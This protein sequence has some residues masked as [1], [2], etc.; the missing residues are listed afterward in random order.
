MSPRRPLEAIKQNLLDCCDAPQSAKYI[1]DE[2]LAAVRA[3]R[4][5]SVHLDRGMV[6]NLR[7]VAG[8]IRDA[9]GSPRSDALRLEDIADAIE[10]SLA[11]QTPVAAQPSQADE[12]QTDRLLALARE[13]AF[14]LHWCS[15]HPDGDRQ[16]TFDRFSAAQVPH[17][18][19]M[20]D[21]PHPDC[22]LVTERIN[23]LPRGPVSLAP[24]EGR[25]NLDAIRHCLRVL[26]DDRFLILLVDET[27][28]A[29]AYISHLEAD[30][31][32]LTRE[33]RVH[34]RNITEG[35]AARKAEVAAL[36]A[37]VSRLKAERST[38]PKCGEH[39]MCAAGCED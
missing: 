16:A 30:L 3:E 9:S 1:L 2:L 39:R 31:S 27:H 32:R 4:P 20:D 34:M 35:E 25:P 26:E 28:K 33:Y 24:V 21:C 13:G 7:R 36:E 14:S 12:H 5:S 29:L 6:E 15:V 37:E 17:A 8:N 23:E 18:N 38:C 19:P 10:A 22:A 11:P